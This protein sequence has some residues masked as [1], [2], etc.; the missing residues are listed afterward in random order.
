MTMLSQPPQTR[1]PWSES[2]DLY[3]RYHDEE[4]GV[5][6]YDQHKLFDLLILEGMQAG[7]SWR[8]IL[9]KREGIREALAGL[10]PE[11]LA[12]VNDEAIEALLKGSGEIIR[13]RAKLFAARN[14]ARAYLELCRRED[15][16]AWLWQF[17]GGVPF[18]NWH[19]SMSQVPASTPQSSEMSKALKKL[20][21]AFV[22]PTICYAYMQSAGMVNDHLVS[23]FRHEAC[24]TLPPPKGRCQEHQKRENLQAAENHRD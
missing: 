22:G 1:C 20:G 21:F 8:T 2:D 3:K 7:L 10:V 24:R 16:V 5:A 13:N 14:N 18:V 4:W 19:E 15:A 12:A 17:V 23:C 11:K 6:I 9:G